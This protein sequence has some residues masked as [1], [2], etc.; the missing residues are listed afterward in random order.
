MGIVNGA[1]SFISR[2]SV[3]ANGKELYQCN[4]ANHSVN[5]KNLLEYNKS[6]ADSVAT[7]EFYFFDTSRNANKNRFLRKN[8]SHRGNSANNADEEG[9]MSSFEALEDK[10]LPNTKIEINF[11]Y[12]SST[13]CTSISIQKETKLYGK[14]SQTVQMDLS[15]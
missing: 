5:I 2:L 12:S 3:L 1:N 10:L 8:V 9:L 4:Y 15:Q 6:Y 11:D 7:N 14:L 13:V